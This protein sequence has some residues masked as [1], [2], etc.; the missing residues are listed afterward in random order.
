MLLSKKI[1]S[2]FSDFKVLKAL[3]SYK[4]SAAQRHFHSRIRN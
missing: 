4:G 2:F 1:A 3:Q